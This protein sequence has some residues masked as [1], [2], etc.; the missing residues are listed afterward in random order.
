M[1]ARVPLPEPL[2]RR[3]FTVSEGHAAGLGDKRMRGR[4]LTIPF[5]GVRIASSV[6]PADTKADFPLFVEAAAAM[7]PTTSA[8]SHVTAA[9]L[10]GLPLPF[11]W[12]VEEGI[13]VMCANKDA[14]SRHR[15]IVRHRGLEN[16]R[17][18]TVTTGI[19]AT[20]P[21]ST[22]ADLAGFLGRDDLIVLGDAVI[23]PGRPRSTTDLHASARAGMRHRRRLLAAL[24]EIR[25]GSASPMETRLRL[26]LTRA[27]IPGPLLN[28]DLT[29][30]DGEWLACVDLYWPAARLVVEFDGDVHRVTR[31]QWQKDLRRR[32][33]LTES[34]YHVVV[35]SGDDVTRTPQHTIDLV[36][37]GLGY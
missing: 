4:D 5:R 33:L 7:L 31:D 10:L 34:A 30:A 1:T 6:A 13:H 23:G 20:D 24:E 37:R 29:D 12:A 19:D 3:P 18:V 25:P 17:T 2:D 22:W 21:P 9:R 27:G 15:G 35:L 8:F 28:A 16:R 14:G 11:E 26:L 32:R 36:R